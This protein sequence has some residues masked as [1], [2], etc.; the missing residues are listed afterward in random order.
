MVMMT[1][2]TAPEFDLLFTFRLLARQ[3]LSRGIQL[4]KSFTGEAPRAVATLAIANQFWKKR[5]IRWLP[6]Q[7][8]GMQPRFTNRYSSGG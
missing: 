2:A 3:D 7:L 4:A 8:T 5:K 6:E 1:N